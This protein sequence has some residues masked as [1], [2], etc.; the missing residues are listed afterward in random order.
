MKI[1]T[2]TIVIALAALLMAA[3]PGFARGPQNIAKTIHNLAKG[4]PFN[5][6]ESDNEDEVCVFCHTPHGGSN[7]GP[8]WNK[9]L[10]TQTFNHYTSNSLAAAV[11]SSTRAVSTES[12]LCL[13]CHDGILAVNRVINPT[14]RNGDPLIGGGNMPMASRIIFPGTGVGPVIGDAPDA[15]NTAQG[16]G[17]DLTDDHP[18]S[19]SYSDVYTEYTGNGRANELKD[20]ATIEAM[21]EGPRLFGAGKRVE[22]SSCHDPHVDYETL[23]NEAYTPF[24]IMP[25]NGSA[26][27][28]ACHTK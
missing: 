3:A 28:L 1:A 24:L 12:L 2:K 15:A 10:P 17:N 16:L 27:C 20:V 5:F 23:G 4:T 13:A 11:G 8:L 22:C 6:Y 25:N 7:N 18:I 14:N 9:D 19:F 21:L 26:M